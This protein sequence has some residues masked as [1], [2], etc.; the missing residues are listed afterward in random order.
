MV[1]HRADFF[2]QLSPSVLESLS[3]KVGKLDA[4]AMGGQGHRLPAGL[5]LR[6]AD[7]K[8]VRVLGKG[9][10][11][12]VYLVRCNANNIK[13]ALKCIKKEK[14]I[15]SR[16][17]EHVVREKEV[18]EHLQSPFLVSLAASFQ[19]SSHLYMMMQL[20]EGGELFNYLSERDRPLSE[21]E[22]RFYGACVVLGLEELQRSGIAWRDL[23]PEN[24]LLDVSGYAMLT[25]FGFAKVIERG[26]KSF[27]M[28]GALSM[29]LSS[30]YAF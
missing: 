9:A 1:L 25:D 28:C 22:A 7:L 5:K 16:L 26:K 23:K 20:V 4:Q 6:K 2:K 11:G 24:I 14:V 19:D 10:F 30:S 12:K 17:T 8:L 21:A 27:T 13:Y 29:L 18:M 15:A 3:V